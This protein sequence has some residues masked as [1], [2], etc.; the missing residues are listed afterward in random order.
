MKSLMIQASMAFICLLFVS[1]KAFSLSEEEAQGEYFA[2][3]WKDSDVGFRDSTNQL[4][5]TL[6]DKKGNESKRF[7]KMNVIEGNKDDLGDKVLLT[8]EEPRNIKNSRVLIHS[9]VGVG[10]D[11][12]LYLPSIKRV[13]YVSSADRSG[14]FSGSEFSYEDIGSMEIGNYSYKLLR[15][16]PCGEF[17]C[18][19][20][21]Q[22][23][24]YPYSGYSSIQV[25]YDKKHYRQM[26]IDFYDRKKAKLKTL[27]LSKYEQYLGK[28]WRALS[29]DM[30]NHITG[31]NT[32]LKSYNVKF[33]TGLDENSFEPGRLRNLTQYK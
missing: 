23:P 4:E 19:V 8:F 25:W 32:H 10:D 18:A 15:E 21:E 16:E 28:Y 29:M 27:V 17:K 33:Q 2:Q 26:K 9:K 6:S 13:K 1:G 30:N 22:I 3:K 5:M 14:A 12:W 31:K 7:I 24:L 11:V 20:V